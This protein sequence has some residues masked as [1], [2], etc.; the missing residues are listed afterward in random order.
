MLLS[1]P[2]GAVAA[3]EPIN[4][5][6]RRAAALLGI[7]QRTLASEVAAGRIPSLK[8]RGRR[9]FNVETLRRL[10]VEL[11]QRGGK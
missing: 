4:V 1:H 6:A 3:T 7:S 9:L 2:H 8:I 10:S 5:D 11:S